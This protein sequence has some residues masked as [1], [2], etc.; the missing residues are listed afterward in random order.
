ML[1][2][3]VVSRPLRLALGGIALTL[4]IADAA[5]GQQV[6]R[7]RTWE[8]HIPTGALIATGEQRGVLKNAP[9]SAI[10][11]GWNA[12]PHLGLTGTFTW[13]RSRDVASA[14]DPKL[15]VFTSDLGIETR[16]TEWRAQS[17]V[18]VRLFAGVGGG[19]RSYNYRKLDVDATHNLAGYASVGAVVGIR[20]VAL[21]IEARDY[22]T[23][24]QPLASA[25]ES[26]VRNDVALMVAVRFNRKR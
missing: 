8:L 20:R 17:P 14:G 18:S 15:D 3:A 16:T 7:P 11:L 10:Q 13:A 9:L 19:A 2:I 1:I 22:A 24:F 12:R 4:F 6:T 5:R 23:G 25:G 21:R 26:E